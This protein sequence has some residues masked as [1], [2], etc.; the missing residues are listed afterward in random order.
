M[1]TCCGRREGAASVSLPPLGSAP[2]RPPEHCR[3]GGGSPPRAHLVLSRHGPAPL[4]EHVLDAADGCPSGLRVPEQ[5]RGA[6][7]CPVS[8]GWRRPGQRGGRPPK[9]PSG[10]SPSPGSTLP[11]WPGLF[12]PRE[13]SILPTHTL[14]KP[15]PAASRLH[16]TLQ[17]CPRWLCGSVPWPPGAGQG[18]PPCVLVPSPS[19]SP[20]REGAPWDSGALRWAKAHYAEKFRDQ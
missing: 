5:G 11:P 7:G 14:G 16:P 3:P 8:E 15:S 6:R 20:V 2:R 1:S 4:Q 19:S 9:V 10:R 18:L 17:T 13:A 12:P